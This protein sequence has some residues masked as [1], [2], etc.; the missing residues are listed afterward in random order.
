[1]LYL[2][3]MEAALYRDLLKN[4]P[5]RS[6]LY[7]PVNASPLL[8]VFIAVVHI[9]N[10]HSH[11]WGHLHQENILAE[12]AELWNRVELIGLSMAGVPLSIMNNS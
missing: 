2:V 7:W 6:F 8:L 9:L 10:T 3:P 11:L 12:R 5:K 1:M 4:K